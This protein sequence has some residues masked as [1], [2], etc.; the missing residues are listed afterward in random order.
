MRIVRAAA[1]AALDTETLALC[2]ALYHVLRAWRRPPS[3][4][5]KPSPICSGTSARSFVSFTHLDVSVP[6]A[7]A[8]EEAGVECHLET[9]VE[10]DT[11]PDAG[12]LTIW[13]KG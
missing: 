7:I 2:P 3:S 8:V 12:R 4:S 6:V 10:E 1:P 9:F 5:S 11:V 13:L